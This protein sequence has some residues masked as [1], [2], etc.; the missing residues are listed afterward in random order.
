[1]NIEIKKSSNWSNCDELD[2][3]Y[4]IIAGKEEIDR[5]SEKQ[6]TELRDLI[7]EYLTNEKEGKV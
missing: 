3:Y 1:M 4:T 7:N 5:L 6:L 2:I